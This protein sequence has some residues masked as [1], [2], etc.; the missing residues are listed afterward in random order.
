MFKCICIH[1]RHREGIL[2]VSANKNDRCDTAIY[3]EV[4]KGLRHYAPRPTITYRPGFAS[5]SYE[6][7]IIRHEHCLPYVQVQNR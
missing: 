3:R 1:I 5:F 7:I 2:P 4:S 6:A